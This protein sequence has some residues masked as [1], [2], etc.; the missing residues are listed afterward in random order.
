MCRNLR[1]FHVFEDGV[2]SR[3]FFLLIHFNQFQ[4]N[5]PGINLLNSFIFF[6]FIPNHLLIFYA[7]Y[8]FF[9]FENV[10][11]PIDLNTIFIK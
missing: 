6:F 10:R 8:L 1:P 7:T 5:L 2:H 3:F 9:I 11:F 4:E